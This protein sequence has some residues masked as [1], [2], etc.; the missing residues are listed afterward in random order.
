MFAALYRF[1]FT[2]CLAFL[3]AYI[4]LSNWGVHWA[5]FAA[6]LVISTPLAYSYVNLARLR[7]NVVADSIE[8]M[9]LPIGFWEEV[10]FRLQRLVRN[11]KQQIRVIEKQ[12]HRFIE[13]F[14]A[15]PN[16]IVMLDDQDQIEWCNS[17]AERFFGLNYKRDVMQKINFLIRRPEFI[18]YLSRR[19]FDEPLL[20]ERM[21]PA[22]NLSLMLQ[23]FPYS[24]RRHLLL[25]QDVTDLQRADAMRRDFVANVS[26]EMRTPITVLM[27]FLETLHSLELDKSQRDQY[28]EMMMSQAQR[29][30][31]LVEDL[32]TLANLEANTLPAALKP[33]KVS[34]LMALLKNDAEALSQ[35][36]HAFDFEVHSPMNVLGEERE[37]LSAFSNLV[38]NAVRYTPD[39]G[40]IQV[41]WNMNAQG[42]GEFSVQDSGPGIASEHLSRLT[43]RFYRVD[44][45]R[46]RDTGG[47]GLG[48]AIVKHIATRHQA[49]LVI[50][51]EPGKGSTF[52][53]RFPKERM[54]D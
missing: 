13:A 11:L 35:G 46:S 12:H 23:A 45:S 24:E 43:E 18:Q 27:G 42:Q 52:T 33:I 7:K 14:Q 51:S 5:I 31:S 38:S 37:V 22:S 32:L 29:M 30:K 2:L 10:L 16:G 6:V 48:L 1:I 15:S 44:R 25:V 3:A 36:R 8:N 50:N 21:G 19:H 39:I 4:A 41:S 20:L 53:L 47:T 9:S 49:Q 40:S 17:I 34:T 28:F 26:H 54:T